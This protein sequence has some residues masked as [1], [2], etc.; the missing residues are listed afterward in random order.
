[1]DSK[2]IKSVEMCGRTEDHFLQLWRM[3]SG[4]WKVGIVGINDY[5]F[6][7]S[8]IRDCEYLDEAREFFNDVMNKSKKYEEWASNWRDEALLYDI[9][10]EVKFTE[11]CGRTE[12][13][14]LQLWRM[15]SEKWIL[16]VVDIN[17]FNFGDTQIN[18]FK[19]LTEARQAFSDALNE[20]KAKEEWR[21]WNI[22]EKDY[23]RNRESEF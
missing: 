3:D 5:N 21:L 23:K 6:G 16:A 9:F 1:M 8:L 2:I 15:N 4:K 10:G 11:M 12:D 7:R 13:H 20:S 14:F 22:T 19:D 17:F 18:K